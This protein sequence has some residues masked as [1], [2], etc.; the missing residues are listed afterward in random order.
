MSRFN[1]YLLEEEKYELR[2][3][4]LTEQEAIDLINKNCSNILN[5]YR[6]DEH[7]RIWRGLLQTG[8]WHFTDPSKGEH[9]RS[10]GQIG[11]YY[12][13]LMDNLPNWKA[14]PKRS[15]SVICTTSRNDSRNYGYAHIVFPYDNAK[16]G[17]APEGDIWISFKP[18]IHNLRMFVMDLK[19][20]LT[21]TTKMKNFDKNWNTLIR[22]FK[23][24]EQNIKSGDISDGAV[25]T[26]ER[27]SKKSWMNDIYKGQSYIEVFKNHMDPIK[28]KFKLT[29]DPASVPERHEIWTDSKCVIISEW[30]QPEVLGEPS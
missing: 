1:A 5:K 18:N 13:L 15:R 6:K 28:N 7:K 22:A 30:V 10:K 16:F 8:N 25:N 29:K 12:T 27:L 17:V 14:Y 23:E 3:K 24:S 11:E 9:R 26:F 19:N 20:I 21:I 4:M 2:S